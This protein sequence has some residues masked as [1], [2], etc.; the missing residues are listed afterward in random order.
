[1]CPAASSGAGCA[2]RKGELLMK[3]KLL[4]TA[5][6]ALALAGS[7]AAAAVGGGQSAGHAM[8]P[9]RAAE[10]RVMQTTRAMPSM[11]TSARTTTTAAASTSAGT[12]TTTTTAA[13]SNG[14]PPTTL[15]PHHVT[16]QPMASCEETGSPPGGS[17]TAPGSAFNPDGNAGTHYAGQQP[18]NSRNTASVSQYDQACARHH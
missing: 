14:T 9:T 8:Q 11:T 7:A 15:S 4:S 1:M 13:A 3:L 12:S 17:A 6:V 16:G 10:T 5:I 18:Q 2:T